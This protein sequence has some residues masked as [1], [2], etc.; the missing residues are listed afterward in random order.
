MKSFESAHDQNESISSSSKASDTAA[1]PEISASFEADGP[2]HPCPDESK[3]PNFFIRKL[4]AA[5]NVFVEICEPLYWTV[6]KLFRPTY[7]TRTQKFLSFFTRN[8][9]L[10]ITVA[11]GYFLARALIIYPAR[12]VLVF[13][14]LPVFFIL[15][16]TKPIFAMVLYL[17]FSLGMIHKAIWNFPKLYMGTPLLMIAVGGWLLSIATGKTKKVK[18]VQSGTHFPILTLWT[19]IYFQFLI[20]KSYLYHTIFLS[21]FFLVYFVCI[22]I[23]GDDKQKFLFL[24]YGLVAIYGFY[25]YKVI[26]MSAYYGFGTDYSVSAEIPGR[27]SDNNELA[28]CLTMTMPIFYALFLCARKKWVRTILMLFFLLDIVAIIY[29]R[30]RAGYIALAVTFMLTF[31]KLVLGARKKTIPAVVLLLSI[32]TGYGV[33][34][35]KINERIEGIKNWKEDRSAKNRILSMATGLEMFK[36]QPLIGIGLGRAE[37]NFAEYCP[38][39]VVFPTGW[40]DDDYITIEGAK[41]N[42]VIHNAYAQMSGETGIVG[43][44]CFILFLA[45][46]ISNMHRLRRV[47]PKT[48]ENEWMFYISYA[49]E[50][51]IIA[52]MVTALSLNNSLAGLVYTIIACTTSLWHIAVGKNQASNAK[53]NVFTVIWILSLFIYWLYWTIWFRA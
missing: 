43:I 8:Y 13:S 18:F 20:G 51:S 30:S 36:S 47:V 31:F 33:F 10:L 21:S 24:L 53:L 7:G 26:R 19:L 35:K 23:V 52:Y 46:P 25:A 40:G 17:S 16:F 29:T 6:I 2:P 1:L 11:V 27:L 37:L 32:V 48:A 3:K 5:L 9:V 12:H 15:A 28:S 38:P 41:K 39:T 34:H 50:F 45:V 44:T 49:L 42:L 22:H 4:S 14:A